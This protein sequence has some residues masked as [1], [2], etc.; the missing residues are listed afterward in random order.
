ML[1]LGLLRMHVRAQGGML[2]ARVEDDD[3]PLPALPKR[4]RA[5][6]P[7]HAGARP[8]MAPRVDVPMTI[9]LPIQERPAKPNYPL[10]TPHRTNSA[11]TLC[12]VHCPTFHI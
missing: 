12:C 1:R 11:K 3:Q 8:A 6:A 4:R 9:A 2:R 7:V 10:A 5:A